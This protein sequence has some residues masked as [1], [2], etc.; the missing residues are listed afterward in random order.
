MVIPPDEAALEAMGLNPLDPY[1]RNGT[2]QAARV[3]GLK[4]AEEVKNYGKYNLLMIWEDK[5]AIFGLYM[6]IPIISNGFKRILF[7]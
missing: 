3:Q 4:I 1:K 7:L 6:F 5:S 2:A